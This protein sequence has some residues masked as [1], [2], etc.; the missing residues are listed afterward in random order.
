MSRPIR[1]RWPKAR[2]SAPAFGA[3]VLIGLLYLGWRF[4]E[5][6]LAIAGP[7][8]S[9]MAVSLILDPLVSKIQQYV[10]RG[11][12][13]PALLLVFLLFL[14]AIGALVVFV[15]PSLI[16]QAQN[17]ILK[18]PDYFQSGREAINKY[19]VTHRKIGPVQLPPDLNA[20]ADQY[21]DQATTFLRNK[22]GGV[23]NLLIGSV[24]N[25]LS[26]ILVPIITFYILSDFDRLRARLFYLF[27][28]RLRPGALRAAQ[29][30]GGVFGNYVRGLFTIC[31]IYALS[32]MAF[33][34]AL[35]FVNGF[36]G[37]RGYALLLGFAAGI[38]YAVPYVGAFATI[39]LAVT[40]M[41]TTGGGA[42][43]AITAA[44]GLFVLNQFFDN[45]LM[46]KIVG[47]GVGLHPILS[48]FALLLGANLFGLWGM[49]LSV[50]VAA[51]IQAVLFRLYPR[52]A[53]PTPISMLLGLGGKEA[54]RAEAEKRTHE[55]EEK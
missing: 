15:L 51:S 12:R 29:D 42:A 1:Q 43:G 5:A 4:M 36:S 25:L 18:F 40:V 27:P 54:R 14:L 8:I 30:V 20:L 32:A 26:A 39:T 10:T 17:L 52:L 41:L 2:L 16:G 13:L 23:A 47:G 35:S 22:A 48:V 55:E 24:G 3:F 38:L 37:V 53:A 21:G 11:K 33:L 31:S 19:L 46:P 7:F 44:I 9:A 49:L 34:F 28:S 45:V 6:T 50:P